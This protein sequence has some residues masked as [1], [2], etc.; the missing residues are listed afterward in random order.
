[1][2][3]S[4]DERRREPYRTRKHGIVYAIYGTLDFELERVIVWVDKKRGYVS[5]P[6][7]AIELNGG[8]E[9]GFRL[10]HDVI[11]F[12]HYANGDYDLVC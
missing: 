7:V 2:K 9:F 4:L 10:D 11:F 1:M 3:C 8:Y 12:S 5:C 6:I